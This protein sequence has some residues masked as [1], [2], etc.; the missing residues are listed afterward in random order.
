MF[1][2]R[3]VVLDQH[4]PAFA[5]TIRASHLSGDVPDPVTILPATVT[6]PPVHDPADMH[7]EHVRWQ[8][9]RVWRKCCCH[10]RLSHDPNVRT[11]LTVSAV[12]IVR[13]E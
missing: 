6:T 5:Q 11:R 8:R 9:W 7:L 3:N 13:G 2:T 12:E 10:N 4:H 1:A